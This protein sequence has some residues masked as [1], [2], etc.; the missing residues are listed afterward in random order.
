MA[1]GRSQGAPSMATRAYG[2]LGI[3]GGLVLISAW[4][5]NLPW[6]W[7]LFNLRL[8]LFN[9][10]AI[11]VGLGVHRLQAPR[12]P[13]VSLAAAGA[14]ILANA[15]YLVMI[16]LSIGRPIYPEPDPDFR[17]I[18]FYAAM[19]LWLTDAA[20]GLVALRLGVVW[21]W[22]AAALLVGSILSGLGPDRLG[23]VEGPFAAIFIPLS[24]IGIALNGLAWIALG[25][26]LI[27]PW[28]IADE[29]VGGFKSAATGGVGGR[30]AQ[31]LR[32]P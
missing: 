30:G 13:G 8:V 24:Q 2:I 32:T 31:E 14:M 21:P 18:M 16:I 4:I 19:A 6:T 9:V 12:S 10:G 22:A 1:S 28:R 23:L 29:P 26:G 7:E 11:A 3:V 25:I 5:P 27:R 15:A 20:F 17:L